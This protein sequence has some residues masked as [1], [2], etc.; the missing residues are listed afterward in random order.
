MISIAK[1]NVKCRNV[2]YD[3][4]L[5]EEINENKKYD[6]IFAN[7]IFEHV[8]NPDEIVNVVYNSLKA[9]GLLFVTVPNAK[10]LYR[11]M[12]VSMGLL[13]SIYELT[14]ND[15]N[16]GHRRVYCLDSIC[17]LFNKSKFDILDKGGTFVKQFADF[18]LEMMI[19][20]NIVNEE[21]L[22]AMQMMG[23]KYPDISGSVYLVLKKNI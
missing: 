5:F 15:I 7:Y 19:K 14:E 4:R 13:N 2:E 23:K 17:E 18:Q 9:N 12:S 10:S 3:C 20:N 22:K 8:N 6:Y 16:H 21:C 1:K 11:Q